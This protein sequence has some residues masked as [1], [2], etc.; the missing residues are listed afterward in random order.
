MVTL[1]FSPVG[2]QHGSSI[3]NRITKTINFTTAAGP[4]GLES[5]KAYTIKLHLGMN[6]VKYDAAVGDWETGD[7]GEAWLPAN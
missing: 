1:M 5:G 4:A 2:I 6:S 7:A 3:E